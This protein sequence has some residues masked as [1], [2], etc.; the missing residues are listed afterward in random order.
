[1]PGEADAEARRKLHEI[2]GSFG[3]FSS[4]EAL[5]NPSAPGR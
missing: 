4:R 2:A 1:M 5:F 3:Q